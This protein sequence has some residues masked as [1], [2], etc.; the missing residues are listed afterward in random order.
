[1]RMDI[2]FFIIYYGFFEITHIHSLS[3]KKYTPLR[4]ADILGFECS[5]PANHRA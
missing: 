5:T 4:K 2:I 1:M 3:L